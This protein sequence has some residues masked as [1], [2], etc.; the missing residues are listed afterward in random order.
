MNWLDVVII[1]VVAIS[2]FIGLWKGLIKIVMSLVGLIV[3]VVLAGRY[4]GAL[5]EHLTL[6]PNETL[7]KITAFLIILIGVMVIASV[8]A[9]L[10]KLAASA[11]MLGWVNRIGGALF[12]IALG[13]LLCSAFLALWARLAGP[14]DAISESLLARVLLDYFPLVLALLPDEF[15]GIRSIFEP[16]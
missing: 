9:H 14:D 3:G 16:I 5:A 1:V 4:Y 2:A 7:A 12:G 11:I 6:I 8:V 15:D 10:L 13:L